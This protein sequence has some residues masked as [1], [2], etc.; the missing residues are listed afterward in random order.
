[1]DRRPS[2]RAF[3]FRWESQASIFRFGAIQHERNPL[4]RG[5]AEELAIVGLAEDVDQ[6]LLIRVDPLGRGQA[7]RGSVYALSGD[8]LDLGYDQHAREEALKKMK[9]VGDWLDGMAHCGKECAMESHLPLDPP[10]RG[11]ERRCMSWEGQGHDGTSLKASRRP[12][13]VGLDAK[14]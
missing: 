12:V 5:G 11:E 1:M 13:T 7:A 3:L 4:V 8:F 10:V 14:E 9:D 6:H 2:Q